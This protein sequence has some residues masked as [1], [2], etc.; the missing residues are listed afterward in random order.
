L[1]YPS[2]NQTIGTPFIELQTVDSTNNYA[3]AQIHAGLAQHGLAIFTHEQVAGKGQ[4]GR[5]WASSKGDNI[6]LSVI[7]KPTS[8]AVGQQFQLSACAALASCNFLRKYAGDDVSIKWPNDLYWKDR[9]AGGILIESVVRTQ[10]KGISTWEWAIIGVGINVNQ[11]EFPMDLPNPVSLKQ[12]TGKHTNAVE[13][14]KELC[15]CLDHSFR[16]LITNG[17]ENILTA[18][19]SHFYKKGKQVRLKKD[20]RVFEA[21]IEG[22]SPEGKLV[23]RHGIEEQFDL[24]EIQWLL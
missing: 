12:V 14:A 19:L 5:K 18:Y 23:V 11:T 13:L 21:T 10:E 7:I 3:L 17:F 15:E 8:L 1:P 16:E 9:K 24:G 20:N 4:R 2:L 22:I 6:A